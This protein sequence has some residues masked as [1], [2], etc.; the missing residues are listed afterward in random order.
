MKDIEKKMNKLNDKA[1]RKMALFM[2]KQIDLSYEND[3]QRMANRRGFG[4]EPWKRTSRIALTKRKTYPQRQAGEATGA[5][6]FTQQQTR[7]LFSANTLEDTGKMRASVG[8]EMEELP[9]RLTAF[10]GAGVPYIK[11]HEEGGKVSADGKTFEVP[12]RSSQHI[13]DGEQAQLEKMYIK[14]VTSG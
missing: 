4:F 13:T 8:I 9:N 6:G 12:I 2:A 5:K 1:I 14:G 7:Y 3:G 11:V 10:T